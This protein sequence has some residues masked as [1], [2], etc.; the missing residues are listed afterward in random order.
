M[1]S[2]SQDITM[3]VCCHKKD[4]FRS[5]D[6]FMPIHVGKAR[7]S[8]DLGI[9]GDDTGDNISIKNPNFCELTAH[10]WY[11]KNAA[12]KTKYIGLSHYRRYFDLSLKLPYGQSYSDLTVE[13]ALAN[14]PQLPANIDDIFK[15]YDIV[16]AKRK[17]YPFSL[18]TDY[19]ICHIMED[20][21]TLRDVV[22]DRSSEML[23]SFDE[24]MEHNNKLAHYNMFITS[25]EIFED[26]T[27]W[28]FDILFE[29]EKRVKISPY[30]YQ[31]RIFGYMSE[32]LLNVY[33]HYKKLRIK[34][35]PI[36]MVND[37]PQK[38]P[39]PLAT[40]RNQ[41]VYMLQDVKHLCGK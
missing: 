32:R 30:P 41:I 15:S 8:E 2:N 23:E 33:C 29:V 5:G 16:L 39:S 3:L 27:T 37:N 6:G 24:V 20:Y 21:N 18:K 14:P 22:S 11:W 4:Y 7:S 35:A 31:A 9:V 17:I 34:Y 38:Q 1:N 10:Y 13:Q 36:V 12:K 26:Y 19:L 40:L 28:M 25:Q